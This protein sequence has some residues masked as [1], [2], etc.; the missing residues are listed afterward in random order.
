M[1]RT[2]HN[3]QFKLIRTPP[4]LFASR[5]LAAQPWVVKGFVVVIVNGAMQ[6]GYRA[7]RRPTCSCLRE[8]SHTNL[9]VHPV[10]GW[11]LGLCGHEL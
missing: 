2:S 1:P 7:W 10:I 8:V 4:R 3:R 5:M 6:L 9:L 11:A